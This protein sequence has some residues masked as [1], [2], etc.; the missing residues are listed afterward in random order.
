MRRRTSRRHVPVAPTLRPIP[1]PRNLS[2]VQRPPHQRCWIEHYREAIQTFQDRWDIPDMEQYVAADFGLV[3]STLEYIRDHVP[4]PDGIAGRFLEWG[5][6]FGLI[7]NLAADLGFD[8]VGIESQE[9]LIQAGTRVQ[10]SLDTPP[11]NHAQLEAGNFLPPG[12]ERFSDNPLHPS[13]NH[14]AADAYD[15]IGLDLD[16]FGLIYSYPWPGEN[17]FHRQVFAHHAAPGAVH[18]QFVGPNDVQAWQ[19]TVSF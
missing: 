12:A 3:V 17:D 1:L 6:G 4:R 14:P 10:R 18:V 11:S 9:D 15:R 7:A 13:L 19:K 16:D 2:D 8:A 5:C